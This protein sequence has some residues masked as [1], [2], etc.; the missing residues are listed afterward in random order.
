M[1]RDDVRTTV[2]ATMLVLDKITK[3]TRTQA[4]DLMLSILRTNEDR[5]VDAV[6]RLTADT[7]QPPTD[8]QVVEALKSVGIN[9]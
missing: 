8:T 3:R 1:N 6:V 2:R 7:G 4:D 5:I 9:V